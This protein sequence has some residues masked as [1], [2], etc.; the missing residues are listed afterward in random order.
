MKEYI[1]FRCGH[2]NVQT[3]VGTFE[4][5]LMTSLTNN[6]PLD[7]KKLHLL[8][9]G[10][11]SA[12]YLIERGYIFSASF[13]ENIKIVNEWASRKPE[14]FGRYRMLQEMTNQQWTDRAYRMQTALH[15]L[16]A[17]KEYGRGLE[18]VQE[19]RTYKRPQ[20]LEITK[21]VTSFFQRIGSF[22]EKNYDLYLRQ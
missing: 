14:L 12:N 9:V 3:K 8:H 21:E 5:Y 16:T 6:M 1:S 13:A 11:F 20:I 2:L 10:T 4:N 19:A 22:K 17:L 15:Q 7:A 18:F